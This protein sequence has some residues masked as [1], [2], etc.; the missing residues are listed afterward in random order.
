MKIPQKEVVDERAICF[1]PE[2]RTR[3][4][5]DEGQEIVS[6]AV[7]GVGGDVGLAVG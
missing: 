6:M 5:S 7:V 4:V 2:V 1:V 3:G